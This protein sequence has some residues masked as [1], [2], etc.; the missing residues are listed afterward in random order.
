MKWALVIRLVAAALL[1]VVT[2]FCRRVQDPSVVTSGLE[3][4]PRAVFAHAHQSARPS[5]PDVILPP[6]APHDWEPRPEWTAPGPAQSGQAGA[7]Q[8][9]AVTRW[10]TRAYQPPGRSPAELGF[11]VSGGGIR[12]A[13]ITLGALQAPREQLLKATY[14]VSVSGGG[15]TAGALQLAL[16]DARLKDES[17]S[18]TV[19]PG[20]ASTADAFA[21]GSPEEDHIRRHA[22]YLADTPKEA[23]AVSVGLAFAWAWKTKSRPAWLRSTVNAIV[24]MALAVALISIVLPAVIWFFAWLAHRC[25]PRSPPR[26]PHSV[27]GSSPSTRQ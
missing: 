25:L 21:P 10:R 3:G 4:R 17:G 2:L 20:L 12:S 27:P 1:I 8:D 22:K 6:A 11:C 19:R 14:L 13:A 5:H 26:R 23:G 7:Q 24:A 16:T 9:T 15:Y 18:P